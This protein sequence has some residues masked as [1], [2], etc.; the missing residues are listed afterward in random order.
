[1][2]TIQNI[3]RFRLSD[4]FVEPYK[5][6]EVPWGPLG[7]QN[8][9]KMIPGGSQRSSKFVPGNPEGLPKDPRGRVGGTT[10]SNL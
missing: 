2:R 3:R 5:T 7:I 10:R 9:L 1:M 6:A 4:T 8:E